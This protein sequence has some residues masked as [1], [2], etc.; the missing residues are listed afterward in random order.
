[1]NRISF[2]DNR[3]NRIVDLFIGPDNVLRKDYFHGVFPEAT[4]IIFYDNEVNRYV[5]I[6]R[7]ENGSFKFEWSPNVMYELV[8]RDEPQNRSISSSSNSSKIWNWLTI[9]GSLVFIWLGSMITSLWSNLHED[10]L[11]NI[12]QMSFKKRI[13]VFVIE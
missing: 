7:D 10:V 4:G 1:M 12:L 6:P 13:N 2:N 5:G 3:K 9:A 11:K 8:Y